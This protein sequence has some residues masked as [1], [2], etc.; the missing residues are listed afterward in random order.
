MG[1]KYEVSAFNYPYKG[2]ERYKQTRWLIIAIM[3]VIAWSLKYDGV[4]LHKR[5]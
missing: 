4:D 2:A 3:Y 5:S 1:S